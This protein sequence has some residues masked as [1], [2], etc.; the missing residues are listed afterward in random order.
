MTR[1][2]L[3]VT[4]YRWLAT[5]IATAPLAVVVA[6]PL[7]FHPRGDAAVFEP[8]GLWLLETARHVGATMGG[9]VLSGG[10]LT[11]LFAL[12]WSFPLGA[13]V[14]AGNGARG[15]RAW[16]D[17]ARRWTSLLLYQ[18]AAILLS[19][20]IV[21]GLGLLGAPS[22]LRRIG[23]LTAPVAILLLALGLVWLLTVVLDAARM[24]RF[25][26]QDGALSALYEGGVLL[27]RQ[28]RLWLAAGWRTVVA[29]LLVSG[30]VVAVHAMA[31]VGAPAAAMMLVHGVSV[32]A[33]VGLRASWFDRLARASRDEIRAAKS[34]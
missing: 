16:A 12:G 26:D 24:R 22:Q 25:I 15:G 8:G 19:T 9:V 6:G 23:Q 17:A 1:V 11:L 21:V 31:R 27:A 5:L 30:A 28:R 2:L 4:A 10:L 14:A 18:G 33:Y 34:P 13:L 20:L 3:L 29:A 32:L 7:R